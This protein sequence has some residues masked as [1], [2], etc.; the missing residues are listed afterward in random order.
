ML[1]KY[2]NSGKPFGNALAN[3]EGYFIHLASTL[4]AGLVVQP[5]LDTPMALRDFVLIRLQILM[6]EGP[7]QG[8]VYFEIQLDLLAI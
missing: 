7:P 8:F 2:V 5:N 3:S 6:I 4:E 1:I